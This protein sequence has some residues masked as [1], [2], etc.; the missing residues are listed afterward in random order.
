M[1]IF[2]SAEEET[3]LG[4]ELTDI[5]QINVGLDLGFR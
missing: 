2:A 3:S 5:S 1:T 4:F